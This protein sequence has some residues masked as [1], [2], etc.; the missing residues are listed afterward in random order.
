MSQENPTTV[1]PAVRHASRVLLVDALDRVLLFECM[2]GDGGET[3]WITPGGGLEPG[4]THEDAAR[5]E[6]RE[7]VGLS[8]VELGPWVWDRVHTFHWLGRDVTQHERFYLCRVER[9][10]VRTHEQTAEEQAFL[11]GHRAWSVDE[12]ASASGTR[13]SP[14]ELAKWLRLL[15]QDGP[16]AQ[17]WVIG[18]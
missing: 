13:F 15:L 12:I 16:P 1:A 3:F 17:P 5:R 8:D 7:E 18:A 10:D 9:F 6:L 14:R 11:I 4:E 2:A